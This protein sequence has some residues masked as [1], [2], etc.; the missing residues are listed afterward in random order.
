MDLVADDES[1]SVDVL[2][3]FQRDGRAWVAVDVRDLPVAYALAALVDAGAHL[4]QVSVRPGVGAPPAGRRA[5]RGGCRLGSPAGLP[6]ADA[7]DVQRGSLEP[8]LLRAYSRFAAVDDRDLTEGLRQ[9][10]AHEAQQ[11]LDRWPRVVM[12]RRLLP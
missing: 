11:G 2:R 7:D 3:E 5:D 6:G 12:S 4:E 8:P 9:V 1:P 10:R